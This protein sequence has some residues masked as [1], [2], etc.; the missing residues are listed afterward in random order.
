ME[1]VTVVDWINAIGTLVIGAV[2]V[3]LT[4]FYARADKRQ[5]EKNRLD[6]NAREAERLEREAEEA[7][8]AAD[9][10]SERLAR[11]DARNALAHREDIRREFEMTQIAFELHRELTSREVVELQEAFEAK[12]RPQG[13]AEH[14][15]LVA[16]HERSAAR[17]DELSRLIESGSK[18]AVL[19]PIKQ[20]TDELARQADP[21]S[22]LPATRSLNDAWAR[23]SW[24]GAGSF[25]KH[26]I[27]QKI[28]LRLAET[29]ESKDSFTH[30]F[31]TEI[32]KAR[33]SSAATS[34]RSLLVAQSQADDAHRRVGAEIGLLSLDGASYIVDHRLGRAAAKYGERTQLP[35]IEHFASKDE[36]SFPIRRA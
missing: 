20:R 9:V 33:P 27:L 36:N 30:A 21:H 35:V 13:S 24:D 11:E 10:E 23:F 5:Q 7:D 34:G 6:E 1:N 8:R 28:A 17:V 29:H 26:Q 15:V 32:E 25:T 14:K 12:A 31:S 2:G 4:I 22:S 16:L 19:I 18:D 3:A